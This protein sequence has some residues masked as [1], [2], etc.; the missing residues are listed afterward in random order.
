MAPSFSR[1]AMCAFAAAAASNGAS[2]LRLSLVVKPAEDAA[3]PAPRGA[4][5]EAED[6]ILAALRDFKAD[7]DTDFAEGDGEAAKAWERARREGDE[8]FNEIES[9]L[10][11]G[12]LNSRCA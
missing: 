5:K 3:A 8:I 9:E 12:M 2:A 1:F 6:S 4:R 11:L 7:P 10:A